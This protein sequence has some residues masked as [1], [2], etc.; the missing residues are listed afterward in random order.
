MKIIVNFFIMCFSISLFAAGTDECGL[1]KISYKAGGKVTSFEAEVCKNEYSQYY[2]KKCA[3]GCDFAKALKTK[4]IEIEDAMIGSP[5]GQICNELNFKSRIVD[6]EFKGKKTSYIDLCFN[7]D[8]T[9][10]VSTGFLRDLQG[11]DE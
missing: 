8:Q 7:A 9:N 5:G 1:A 3:D 6:I 2:S 4:N 11:G 10:F